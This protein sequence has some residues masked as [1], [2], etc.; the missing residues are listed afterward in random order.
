MKT[1]ISVTCLVLACGLLSLPALAQE[2]GGAPAMTPE[3]QAEMMAWMELAQ[4][5]AHHEHLAPFVGNWKGEVRMWMEPGA[6]ELTEES[7]AEVAWIL[8]GR[9]LEWKIAGQF[10]AMPYE[11]RTLEG[12]NNGDK[13]YESIT[14]DN[15]GTLML[16]SEGSCS[17]GGKTRVM[18]AE[19][20]DV[21]AGGTIGY[22][23]EYTWSDENHFTYTG[24]MDKGEGEFKNAVI[25]YER[26]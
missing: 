26:Q 2:T 11:A 16:F 6:P 7:T 14:A 5:G 12:Y 25:T 23:V 19:F 13:R 21:V 18:S 20:A 22:R 9:F 1:G 8:G 10:G 17:D 24:Y 3:Q 4:P 15:F